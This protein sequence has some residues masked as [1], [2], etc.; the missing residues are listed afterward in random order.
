MRE[1]QATPLDLM[2][3]ANKFSGYR[4]DPKYFPLM[5]ASPLI[6]EA[7]N[8]IYILCRNRKL[9]VED[10]QQIKQVFQENFIFFAEPYNKASKKKYSK[11]YLVLSLV[12]FSLLIFSGAGCVYLPIIFVPLVFIFATSLSAC[13]CLINIKTYPN[14]ITEIHNNFKHEFFA[15]E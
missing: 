15:L 8:H 6:I 4:I 9:S 3:L 5:F 2:S 7:L 11:K 13:A 14:E 10:T 12:F 1:E